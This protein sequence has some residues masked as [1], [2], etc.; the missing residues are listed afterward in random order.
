MDMDL[1]EKHNL[2]RIV[3]ACGKMTHLSGAAVL[4]P[5]VEQVATALPC[6]FDLNELQERAGRVIAQ[7]TGAETGCVTASSAAGITLSVAASM[8]GPDLG[9][10]AQLP[11]TGGMPDQVVLQKGHAVNFG[12]PITQMIRLAGARV[13]EIGSIN[14][15][16]DYHLEHA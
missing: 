3:N 10:I 6:F 4:P 15:A 5:I 16:S 7:A 13:V 1:Y 9:R 8:T 11:D 14:G 2:R 12:A